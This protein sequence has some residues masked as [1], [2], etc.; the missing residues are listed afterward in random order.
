[1]GDMSQKTTLGIQDLALTNLFKNQ[2]LP[3]RTG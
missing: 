1:M 3:K 2:P